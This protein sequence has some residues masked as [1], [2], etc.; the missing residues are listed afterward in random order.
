MPGS[1]AFAGAGTPQNAPGAVPA[2]V[3]GII[4]VLLCS[5]CAPFAWWQGK[6]AENAIAASGGR[7]GGKGMATTGKILGMVGVGLMILGII[8]FIVLVVIGVTSDPDITTY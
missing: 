5:L 8:A 1:P 6:S 2:L 4:G 7:Y 3:L